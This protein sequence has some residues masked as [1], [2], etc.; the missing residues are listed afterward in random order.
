MANHLFN[1]FIEGYHYSK[2]WP[3]KAQLSVIFPEYRVIKAT[4]LAVR[5]LP[6]IAMTTFFVQVNYLGESY[7]PQSLALCCLILSMPLQGYY[8]LGKRSQQVLPVSLATW[9]YQIEDKLVEK[10][11]EVKTVTRKPKYKDMANALKLAFA[12]LDKNWI[13]D[14]L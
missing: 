2:K 10:G 11:V 7:A 1:V 8:W 3:L 14:W 12:E 5:I 9:Y 4:Q 6:L 13:R